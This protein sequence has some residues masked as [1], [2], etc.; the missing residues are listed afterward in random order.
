MKYTLWRLFV[1]LTICL[2][3]QGPPVR[4]EE[5]P[6]RLPVRAEDIEKFVRADHYG[7]YVLGQKVGFGLDSMARG[8][9][10]KDPTYVITSEYRSKLVS[11]GVKSDTHHLVTYEFDARPPYA[12]RRAATKDTN[13]KETK[14]TVVQRT[15]KGYEVT[16]NLAGDKSKQQLATLDYT[17]SDILT[18]NLWL[19]CGPKVGDTL[20]TSSFDL[21]DLKMD[22]VMRKLLATKTSVADGVKVTYHEVEV[23]YPKDQVTGLE[24]YNQD[25]DYLLSMKLADVFELRKEPEK[26]AKNIEFSRDLFVMGSLKI[27][28]PLGDAPK[29]THL[30][31]EVVGKDTSALRPGPRQAVERT[32]AGAVLCKLGK[33]H[34]E[35]VKATEKDL[36]DSLAETTIYPLSHEKVITLAKEAVGDAKTPREKVERLVPFV[37]KY[38]RPSYTAEPLGLLELLKVKKGDC[39]HYALLFTTLARACG[40]PAREVSGLLYMGDDEKAFGPHAWNE[41]V[42]DGVW[43]P[44][45]ASCNQVEL[46]AAHIRFGT[47]LGETLVLLSKAGQMKLKLVEVSRKE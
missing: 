20:T 26:E 16:V 41:V 18:P 14:E 47:R 21:D 33:A 30:V 11:A 37:H 9:D 10:A 42:L 12:L 8:G 4:A 6:T 40:I 3:V 29:V 32:E 5:K 36:E 25:G 24:R 2:L 28:K 17:L 22:K 23:H 7:L 34:G 35:P 31:F 19:S 15:D 43:V 38:I 27:D 1:L 45:D 46:D 13:G 44:I 39:K